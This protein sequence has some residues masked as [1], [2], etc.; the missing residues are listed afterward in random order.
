MKRYNNDAPHKMT[1]YVLRLML[2]SM[3]A[4]ALAP[5]VLAQSGPVQGVC[6]KVSSDKILAGDLAS[7]VPLLRELDPG[8][9][10]GFAPFPGVERVVS[11][12]ELIL[13]ARR[14]GLN[15]SDVPDLCV[16]RAMRLI[17]REEMEA[18]LTEALGASAHAG[19]QLEI[20]E[21][22]RQPLPPGRLEF[23]RSALNQPPISA[24]SAPVIWRGRLMYDQN[25]SLVVWAKVKITVE[26]SI[27]LAAENI[28]AGAVVGSGQV[29]AATTR[30]F[31]FPGQRLDSSYEIIGKLARRSIRAGE[32]FMASALEEAKDVTKGDVIQVRVIGGSATLSFDGIAASSGKKGDTI[33]VHN[34]ASGRNFRAVVEEKGKAVVR[35]T[36]GD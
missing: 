5:C 27:F 36:E 9:V 21:F 22:S 19:A 17:S 35:P 13:L 29:V 25:R 15:L 33:L 2:S 7:A 32:R 4:A 6:L 1:S 16:E 28:P 20:L 11:G 23:Q 18:A 3:L 34:S 10:V 31:P 8:T 12:R 14:Y 24:P 30:E 26:R